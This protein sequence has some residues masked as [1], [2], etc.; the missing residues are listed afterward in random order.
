MAIVVWLVIV[1]NNDAVFVQGQRKFCFIHPH[2]T[3]RGTLPPAEELMKP[4]DRVFY[5]PP[6]ELALAS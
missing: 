2:L 1:E 4:F 5:S 6:L 3:C